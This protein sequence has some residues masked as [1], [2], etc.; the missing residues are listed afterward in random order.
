[1]S[2]LD[3]SRRSESRR[4]SDRFPRSIGEAER[5]DLAVYSAIAATPTPG[6]DRAL[7]RLSRAADYSRLS[8]AA[9]GALGL[10][11]GSRGRRAAILGLSSVAV[12][13]AVMNLGLKTVV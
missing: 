3:T 2:I 11:G 12:T 8:I 10:L 5:L 9:S 1:M 7:S 4:S 6:L 13:S